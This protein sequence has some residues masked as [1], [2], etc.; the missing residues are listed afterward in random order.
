ME[1]VN[2]PIRIFSFILVTG[3]RDIETVRKGPFEAAE[4]MDNHERIAAALLEQGLITLDDFLPYT[5]VA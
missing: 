4:K 3:A 5:L 1:P 2:V